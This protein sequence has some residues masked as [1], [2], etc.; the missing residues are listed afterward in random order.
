MP[1]DAG[2]ICSNRNSSCIG[3]ACLTECHAARTCTADGGCLTCGATT[4][5][6]TF[7]GCIG[8]GARAGVIES[9]TCAGWGDGGVFAD[10]GV[11]LNPGTSPGCGWDVTGTIGGRILFLDDGT[12]LGELS[13]FGGACILEQRSAVRWAVSCPGCE[14]VIRLD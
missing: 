9:S 7:D 10:G 5:C 1:D 6:S 12:Y 13:G 11:T 4:T 3:G 14:F 8:F 2:S